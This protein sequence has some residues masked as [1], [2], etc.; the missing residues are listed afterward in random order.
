[1]KY[2]LYRVLRREE[3]KG[4]LGKNQAMEKAPS[5]DI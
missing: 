2:T 1:M 3:K 5:L 4:I